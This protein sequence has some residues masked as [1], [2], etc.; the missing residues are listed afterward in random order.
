MRF[1]IAILAFASFATAEE[2]Y[3]LNGRLTKD[4]PL[5][6]IAK[7]EPGTYTLQVFSDE[8]DPI[9]LTITVQGG[10]VT[11]IPPTPLPPVP[12]GPS[13]STLSLRVSQLA[14]ALEQSERLAIADNYA[15]IAAS[16][17]AGK[18]NSISL[19]QSLIVEANKATPHDSAKW[20]PIADHLRS[21]DVSTLDEVQAA[22]EQIAAGLRGVK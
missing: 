22:F 16:I 14:V 6:A 19:A 15:K 7:M 10:S 21:V 20:K 11:P 3:V 17:K 13:P 5:I 9:T 12:P 1:L 4:S 18:V 8:A 2:V